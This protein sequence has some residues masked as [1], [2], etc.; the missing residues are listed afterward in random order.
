MTQSQEPPNQPEASRYP[1]SVEQASELFVAAGTPRSPRTIMRYCAAG[2][3]DSIKVDTDHGEK[4]LISSD[5]ID[6]RIE[7]LRQQ[8]AT[9]RHV[10]TR[11]DE[12]GHDSSGRDSDEPPGEESPGMRKKIKSLESELIDQKIANQAKTQY[13]E[14]LESQHSTLIERLQIQSRQIGQ[15]ET[16]LELQGGPPVGQLPEGQA[17]DEV[18]TPEPEAAPVPDLPTE[19]STVTDERRTPEEPRDSFQDAS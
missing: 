2:H 18:A 14:K 9:S 10:A 6:R 8:I 19:D 15:L 5:S 13:I 17:R 7:E 16:R 4:Y 12:S 3:L 11:R 1:L